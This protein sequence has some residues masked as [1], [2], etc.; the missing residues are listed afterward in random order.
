M[1]ANIK[2]MLTSRRQTV[3]KIV[4]QEYIN[5]GLPVASE[6]I[7]RNYQLG[8]SPATIRNDMAYL[9][10]TGYIARPHISAGAI[11]LNKAYR[12]YVE[13]LVRSIEL[14]PGERRLIGNL[15]QDVEMEFEKWAKLAASL[16]SNLIRTIAVV[17]PPKTPKCRFKHL[18]LVKLQE[19]LVLLV[20][21]LQ[22]SKLT[23]QFVPISL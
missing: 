5:K 14:P 2:K 16:L 15:F 10:E 20:L 21:V 12:H 11:P 17:T 7:S 3:L 4:V 23:R 13:S 22:Q 19:F 1:S 8:V 18:E 9:E 6:T